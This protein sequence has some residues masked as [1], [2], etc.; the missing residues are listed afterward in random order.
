M[1]VYTLHIDVTKPDQIKNI[2][3]TDLQ[4]NQT[5]PFT[6]ALPN[7]YLYGHNEIIVTTLCL[8]IHTTGAP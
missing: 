2:Y 7:L 1:E 5:C 4:P 8:T 3:L 6:Q